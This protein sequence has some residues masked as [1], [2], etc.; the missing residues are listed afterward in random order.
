MVFAK[1]R[2]T[3]HVLINILPLTFRTSSLKSEPEK[4]K[5]IRQGPVKIKM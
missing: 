5:P 3:I 4:K 1:L 2:V